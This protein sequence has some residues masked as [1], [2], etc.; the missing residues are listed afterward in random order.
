MLTNLARRVNA[1]NNI[2]ELV[3]K[4]VLTARNYSVNIEF[5][6]KMF[7]SEGNRYVAFFDIL[8]FSSWVETKGSKEVFD[9]LRGFM[10]LMIQASMPDSVVNPD[11]SVDLKQS[12][13]SYVNFSDSIVYYSRDDSYEAFCSM[14]KVC[15]EFTNVIICGPTRMIRGAV[16]HGEF[17]A[18]PE[19]NAYVG[20]ALIDA[21]KL[22]E[23][24]DWI[25]VSL[26]SS[27]EGT[28][29]FTRAQN[30]FPHL[31]V[32]SLV[33]LKQS[34]KKPFCLNWTDNGIVHAS[35]NAFR[36]LDDCLKIGLDTAK[37]NEKEISKLQKR[38]SN[39]RE[40]IEHCQRM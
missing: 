37:D 27:I 16:S 14:L 36:S 21:Y 32:Q 22:E 13:I 28:E 4:V 23:A 24:Q 26:H 30:E 6:V 40:F 7:V 18:D 31:I 10:N 12:I 11:M 5:V 17:Y 35:Y 25:G 29:N 1:K 19:N 33:P 15:V 3:T 38:I 39:T 9:Y 34:S 20:K 8:G 2:K